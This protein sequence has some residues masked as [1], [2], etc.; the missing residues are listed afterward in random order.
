[1]RWDDACSE[2]E[3]LGALLKKGVVAVDSVD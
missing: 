1:L 3:E 2:F